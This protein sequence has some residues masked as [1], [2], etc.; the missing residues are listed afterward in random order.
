M[1]IEELRKMRQ[2]TNVKNFH[3][4]L[5][6]VYDEEETCSVVY[7]SSKPLEHYKDAN[8]EHG[9]KWTEFHTQY[10]GHI[11]LNKDGQFELCLDRS[12]FQSYNLEELEEKLNKYNIDEGFYNTYLH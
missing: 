5:Y 4:I 11:G 8:H 3:N 10:G 6:E 9:F 12:V 1:T 2:I 7:Y